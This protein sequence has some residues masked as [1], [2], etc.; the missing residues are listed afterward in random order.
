MRRTA[1]AQLLVLAV[2]AGSAPAFAQSSADIDAAALARRAHAAM[3]QHRYAEALDAYARAARLDPRDP[4]LPAGAGTAAAVMGR[5]EDAQQWLA[6]ALLLA[7]H[8][9]AASILLGRLQYD[10]G[11]LQDA[12]TTYE[13]ALRFA[14]GHAQL[15]QRLGEWRHELQHHKYLT[16]RDAHFTVQSE[17][18]NDE[19]LV[20]Q[21]LALLEAEY[22][23]LGERLNLYP[24][25]PILVVLYTDRTF[26]D[27][28]RAP[29][30]AA[31]VYDGRIRLPVRGALD[32]PDTLRRV[33]SHELVHAM[34]AGFGGRSVP[35]WINEGLATMLEPG[36]DGDREALLAQSRERLPLR[37]LEDGFRG[38]KGERVA[39]AYVESADAVERMVRMRGMPMVMALLQDLARGV[40][41]AVTF[42]QRM[43]VPF[44]EFEAS[45][46]RP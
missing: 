8:Y 45:I 23:R 15:E 5:N 9:T 39:L 30:W 25:Q 37:E 3:E 32:S 2:A 20:H 38:L 4:V 26:R 16:L 43:Q 34:I 28:T 44:D 36:A 22:W 27:V 17:G 10:A 40:P 18:A 41:F 12:I 31:G 21:V 42:R 13:V 14:P 33:L 19:R 11:R 35:A 6:R 24:T 7:P 29:E 1:L 46:L